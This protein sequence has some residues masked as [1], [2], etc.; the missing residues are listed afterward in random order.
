MWNP[1]KLLQK[2]KKLIVLPLSDFTQRD[3]DALQLRMG[4]SYVVIR[5]PNPNTVSVIETD[6]TSEGD[7]KG[8]F[9]PD[10][11]DAELLEYQRNEELG[12]KKFIPFINQGKPHDSKPEITK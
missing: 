11:S 5:A 2:E 10:M 4:S 1:I 9:M 12:W 3:V 6:Y 7:G 8:E